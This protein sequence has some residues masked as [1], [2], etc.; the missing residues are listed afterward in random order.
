ME[1]DKYLS[2]LKEAESLIEVDYKNDLE[3]YFELGKLLKA[4]QNIFR[5]VFKEGFLK[6]LSLDLNEKFP[7]GYS[8]QSLTAMQRYYE[9]FRNH[10]NLK[11][12]TFQIGWGH[13]I[14]LTKI[15]EIQE[16]EFYLNK[17][18]QNNWSKSKLDEAIQND[19]FEKYINTVE[20]TEYKFNIEKL[21]ID[22][23]KSLLDT[24]INK[25]TRFSVFVGAN[26]SGKSN[27]FEA[28]ELMFHSMYI[29][30]V[31]AIEVFGGK[32]KILNFNNPNNP[33]DIKITFQDKTNFGVNYHNHEIK[34]LKS[35]SDILSNKFIN[36]F[37]R[38][39][40]DN[41]K[42]GLN[43]L[44]V[45]NK[46]WFDGSN[47]SKILQTILKDESKREVFLEQLIIYIPGFKDIKIEPDELD[48]TL[49]VQIFEKGLKQPISG[50]L[51]SEGTY[52][53][54]GLL[55]LLY[56]SDE[57]QF[58]CI[59]EPE[60]GLNPKVQKDFVELFREICEEEGHYIWLTTHSQ[61]IVSKITPQELILVDK[62]EGKTK[63]KQFH[64]DK[65]LIEDYK[66]GK[67]KMDEAWLNN[68]LRGGLPW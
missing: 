36:S 16:V 24:E 13:I 50:Q 6:K 25:P 14:E 32:D 47:L 3:K 65:K 33:L 58:L 19:E 8:Y 55:A 1:N 51:I 17:T 68:K 18:I 10:P 22:N 62:T 44:K 7:K 21:Y 41:T 11:E 38:I 39:F 59:E 61:S 12:L 27:I 67:V 29:T 34:R 37:S 2:I 20:G 9:R 52:S 15:H 48:G 60:N 31:G 43:K 46:L 5:N 45:H 4:N 53:I 35:E 57:P 30:G 54:I 63:I 40:F 26:A 49:K 28:L 42:K 64:S 66:E 23:F 56:Q